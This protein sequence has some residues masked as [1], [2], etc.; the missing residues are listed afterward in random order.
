MDSKRAVNQLWPLNPLHIF[1]NY[2]SLS[3]FHDSFPC[4]LPNPQA[5]KK[6]FWRY[7]MCSIK[8]NQDISE[9]FPACTLLFLHYH[10]TNLYSLHN[11]IKK[12]LHWSLLCSS[13][14]TNLKHISTCELPWSFFP[15]NQHLPGL[16]MPHIY[17]YIYPITAWTMQW[18]ATRGG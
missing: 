17:Q 6:K 13:V 2:T 5:D 9:V 14:P 8:S 10:H 1:F 16:F 18:E 4:W 15:K 7:L 12:E 3:L 11:S